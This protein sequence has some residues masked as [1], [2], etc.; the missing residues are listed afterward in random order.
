MRQHPSKMKQ[1]LERGTLIASLAHQNELKCK[2]SMTTKEAL[3][4]L[5]T[6]QSRQTEIW[7]TRATLRAQRDL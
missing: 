4:M 5:T 3:I 7:A 1:P 6:V 2:A